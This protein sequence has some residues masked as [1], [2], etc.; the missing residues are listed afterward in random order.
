MSGSEVFF[1]WGTIGLLG[2]GMLAGAAYLLWRFRSEK[3]DLSAQLEEMRCHQAELV[4]RMHSIGDFWSTHSTDMLRTV[5]ERLTLLAHRVGQT[6]SEGHQQTQVHVAKFSER[7]AVIDAAQSHIAHL[8]QEIVDL[9]S[10]LA[11]RQARGL[12]GQGHM[13]AIIKDHLP[14]GS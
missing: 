1:L 14:V 9:R 10:V 12:Y 5:D 4:G 13:E 3:G 6:I 8:G 7:L 2:L 11:N